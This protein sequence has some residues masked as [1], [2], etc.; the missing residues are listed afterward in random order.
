MKTLILIRHAKSDWAN[1]NLSDHDRPLNER[2]LTNAPVMAGKLKQKISLPQLW[3]SSSAVRALTT[4]KL[5]CKEFKVDEKKVVSNPELYNTTPGFVID[6][7]QK[8]NDEFESIIIFNHNPTVSQL[9]SMLCNLPSYHLPTCSVAI[10]QFEIDSWKNFGSVA[11]SL[12]DLDYP[13]K[14]Q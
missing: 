13:K 5:F 2:G 1:E 14:Q 6:F 3:V 4:A 8:Q 7:I 11:G 9:V 10:I 12:V